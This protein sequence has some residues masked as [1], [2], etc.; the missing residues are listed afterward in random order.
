[1]VALI[2]FAIVILTG[3]PATALALAAPPDDANRHA[4]SVHK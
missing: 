4:P 1:M 2:T 3:P